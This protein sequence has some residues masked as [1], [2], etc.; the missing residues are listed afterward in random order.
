M[1]V[2]LPSLMRYSLCEIAL[3]WEMQKCLTIYSQTGKA[4]TQ[5]KATRAIRQACWG[6]LKAFQCSEN[7]K[8]FLCMYLVF[9]QTFAYYDLIVEF[10]P[11]LKCVLACSALCLWKYVHMYA[12]LVQ[13]SELRSL[14]T[15]SERVLNKPFPTAEYHEASVAKT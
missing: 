1:H 7:L 9:S 12:C 13:T 3:R 15:S 8:D 2:S 5:S 10:F 14:V 6:E 4:A 11:A